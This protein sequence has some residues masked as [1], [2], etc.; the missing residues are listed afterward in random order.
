[1][2][3]AFDAGF[4]SAPFVHDIA[5]ISDPSCRIDLLCRRKT[6][7]QP[8]RAE[9]WIRFL[10]WPPCSCRIMLI[11]RSNEAFQPIL[12]G[13]AIVVGKG[14]Q[15]STR[16][17]DS[18]IACPTW[19]ATVLVKNDDDLVRGS[20]LPAQRLSTGLDGVSPKRGNDDRAGMQVNAH[21]FHAPELDRT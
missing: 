4:E 12:G 13:N 9:E 15:V 3:V 8:F 16:T 1:M 10:E 5:G 2:P 11:D 19:P 7:P 6:S 21:G 17:P 14:D 18:F 20:G